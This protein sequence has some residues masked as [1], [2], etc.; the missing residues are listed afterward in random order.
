MDLALDGLDGYRA[1]VYSAP[2]PGDDMNTIDNAG[3]EA[4]AA[5]LAAHPDYRVIRRLA[6]RETYGPPAQEA[7]AH[8]V[9]VDT[10]TTGRFD[11]DA[12]IEIAV[13][14]FEY[15]VASGRVVRIVDTYSGLEDPGF[16]IPPESTE[17]HGITDAMVSGQRIDDERVAAVVADAT[18][19]IAHNAAFDRPFLERRLPVFESLPFACS[20]AQIPWSQEAI[21]GTKL[22][23][24]GFL[25]GFFYDAHRSEID[26]RA[27]LEILSRPLP[28]SGVTGLRRLVEAAAE[29][30]LRLWAT[31]SAFETKDLLRERGYRWDAPARCWSRL[32]S[33][34][35]AKA[36]SE[37][38][39][40]EVYR[41]RPA[42]IDVE[43]LDA[44][45]RF[46]HRSGPRK[47]KVI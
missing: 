28:V 9:V 43:V 20:H 6:I 15:E 33:K 7:T 35:A 12:M 46:S 42:Q 30:L 24:L 25:Y 1:R 38:L 23:Y 26:C 14:R 10:E 27:L 36:E 40:A 13:L 32:V 44:R 3:F 31:G 37:W 45:V 5:L 19:V 4:A 2:T 34:D 18:L 29:P 47:A 39:K 17:I 11:G 16:P 22:E 8:A 41:G 21:R